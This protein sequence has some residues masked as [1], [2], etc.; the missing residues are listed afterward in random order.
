[1]N[2]EKIKIYM[3]RNPSCPMHGVS[4]VMKIKYG[5]GIVDWVKSKAIGDENLVNE[6]GPCQE[7]AGISNCK[8][9]TS[10]KSGICKKN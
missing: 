3:I 5:A 4:Q 10:C 9:G 6:G 7:K 1:M 2:Q 8:S